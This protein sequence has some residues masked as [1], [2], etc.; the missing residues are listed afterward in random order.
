MAVHSDDLYDKLCEFDNEEVEG[1]INKDLDRTLAEL[2][3][4][5]E[6]HR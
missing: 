6:D 1:Q 4:W 3:L 5:Q 2:N